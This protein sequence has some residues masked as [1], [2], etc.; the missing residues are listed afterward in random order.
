M[1]FKRTKIVA[2][3]GPS[4]R[5]EKVLTDM[6]HTGID[7]ARLNFS[8]GSHDEH[9]QYIKTI[10]AISKKLKKPVAILQDL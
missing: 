1:R 7:V 3:I 6:I 5:D 2:T 4:S 8:H 10:H 9:A